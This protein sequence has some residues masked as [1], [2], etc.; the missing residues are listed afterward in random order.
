MYVICM[1][2]LISLINSYIKVR[3]YNNK[4]INKVTITFKNNKIICYKLSKLI[5]QKINYIFI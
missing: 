1:N 3:S 5:K 4:N 2:S